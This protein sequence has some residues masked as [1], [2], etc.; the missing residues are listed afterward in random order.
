MRRPSRSVEP[1]AFGARDLE[2]SAGCSACCVKGCQTGDA[3]A[4]CRHRAGSPRARKLAAKAS[5][6]V[7]SSADRDAA[8][9]RGG[10]RLPISAMVR[11]ESAFS[12]PT[13]AMPSSGIC[14]ALQGLDRQQ[15]VVDRAERASRRTS[16]TGSP[17][18]ANRSICRQL[19]RQ[20]HQ[21]SAGAFDDDRTA[22]WQ[23]ERRQ[24]L[25]VDLDAVALGGEMRRSGC[26]QPVDLGQNA[27]G[28]QAGQPLHDLGVRLAVEARPA[29]ASSS[30]RRARA[31]SAGG[32]HGLADVRCRCR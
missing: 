17:Q 29:P 30:S 18:R 20:R 16:T 9:G 2:R 14:R 1:G 13:K 21:Q 12:S 28:R 6:S 11:S 27:L 31:T 8:G 5:R 22:R 19:P 10:A 7:S 4:S 3:A 32:E 23:A 15:G 24:T 26:R 25:D